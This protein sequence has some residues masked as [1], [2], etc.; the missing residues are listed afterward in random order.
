MPAP[1]SPQ[2]PPSR[3][4][5][6]PC[7]K[8][9]LVQEFCSGGSLRQAVDSRN[10]YWDPE[11]KQPRMVGGAAHWEGRAPGRSARSAGSTAGHLPA[12]RRPF[13]QR[14]SRAE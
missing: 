2:H 5:A 3:A 4:P 12:S 10:V 9:F 14:G 7:R 8:L 13:T 1:L 6:L 11:A